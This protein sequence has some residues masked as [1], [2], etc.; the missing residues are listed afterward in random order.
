[1]EK[2]KE[3]KKEKKGGSIY[4]SPTQQKWGK[5]VIYVTVAGA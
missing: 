5:K 1:V 3:K 2:K 4:S